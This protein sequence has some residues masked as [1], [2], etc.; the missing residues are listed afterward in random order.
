MT[1]T[2]MKTTGLEVGSL[3]LSASYDTPAS[4]FEEAFEKG[5]NYFYIGSGRRSTGMKEAI[6]NLVAKG[7][8]DKIAIAIHTYAKLGL[9]AE[10]F[11]KRALKSLNI[12]YADVMI[13]G[14]HNRLLKCCWIRPVP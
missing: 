1:N 8:R 9:L 11:F 13:L 4:A 14:W 2:F 7:H 3:S 10:F 5:C 6:R 12:D